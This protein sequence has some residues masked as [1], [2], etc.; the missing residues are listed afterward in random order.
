MADDEL[1]FDS[2]KC[3]IDAVTRISPGGLLTDATV[4]APPDAITECQLVPIVELPKESPCPD[5]FVTESSIF[6]GYRA[7]DSKITEPALLF[8]VTKGTCCEFDFQVTVEIPEITCPEMTSLATA[9]H[10]ITVTGGTPGALPDGKIYLTVVKDDVSCAFDFDVDFDFTFS[11]PALTSNAEKGVAAVVTQG[12][13]GSLP[14]ATISLT[15]N[16]TENCSFEFDFDFDVTFSCPALTSN[17]AEG[18]AAIVTKG[19]AGDLPE[20]TISLTV[21]NTENCSFEF[22]VDLDLTF[23][24]PA[25]TSNAEKGVA[26]VVTKGTAGDLPEATIAL[27]I[28][29]TENCSFDFDVDFDFTFSCP[30]LTSN[31]E[32][33]TDIAFLQG[34]DGSPP[35]GKIYLAVTNTENCAFEFDVNVEFTFS[36]PD[37]T[38]NAELGKD[39]SVYQG[40]NGAPPEGKIYLTVNNTIDCAFEFDVDFDFTFSCPALTSNSAEG[41]VAV[42]TQGKAGDLPEATISLTINN[43]ED[44]SFE[45]DVELDVTFS[46]PALESKAEEG[47]SIV[48]TQGDVGAL[49]EGSIYL[50]ISNTENCSFEFNVDFDLTFSCPALTSLSESGT[51]VTVTQGTPGALP[52][53]TLYL[54]VE[55]TENCSFEFTIEGDLTFSCPAIKSLATDGVPIVISRDGTEPSGKITLTVNTAEDCS[56]D[57]DVNVDLA[58]PCPIMTAVT[59]AGAAIEIS[60]GIAGKLPTGTIY[61]TA[62]PSDNCSYDFDVALDFTFSCPAITSLSDAGTSVTLT[63]NGSPAVGDTAPTGTIYLKVENTED[64]TFEFSTELELDLPCAEMTSLN[65][66]GIDVYV[67]RGID[68]ELTTGTIYLTVENTED[69]SYEFKADLDIVACCPALTSLSEDGTDVEFTAAEATATP[70]GKIYLTV[71]N[72]ENCIFEFEVGLELS[73]PE[74]SSV[75]YM[76]R[77]SSTTLTING[78]Y[79]GYI[80]AYDP[81]SNTYVD[82][83]YIEIQPTFGG[84]ELSVQTYVGV[85]VGFVGG[86]GP[87]GG[88]TPIYGASP[89]GGGGSSGGGGVLVQVL[90]TTPN[91]FGHYRANL[92]TFNPATN[93]FTVASPTEVTVYDVDSAPLLKKIY[94]G[95]FGGKES[96]GK[97][98][99][100][101]RTRD[102]VACV[103]VSYYEIDENNNYAGYLLN[104]NNDTD[105]FE[106]TYDI[107]IKDSNNL[108][109]EDQKI[110]FGR[111]SGSVGSG[112]LSLYGSGQPIND[113]LYT[114]ESKSFTQAVRVTTLSPFLEGGSY[115]LYDGYVQRFIGGV[116]GFVDWRPIKILNVI[117]NTVIPGRYLGYYSGTLYNSSVPIYLIQYTRT[118]TTPPPA[119]LTFDFVSGI[120]CFNGIFTPEFLTVCIPYGYL[121]VTT[122]TTSTAG[123]ATTSTTSTGAV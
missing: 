57:F 105:S 17:S 93:G 50:N 33:G 10:A 110:Y 60:Q 43:T 6:I 83:N 15:I 39:I 111:F 51:P 68:G 21:N 115:G 11:C 94:I 56:F 18:V 59:S 86:G 97:S 14:E 104:Y 113:Y 19:T 65:D 29:N 54:T 108:P 103:K 90:S 49:P 106:E 38:S 13:A 122:T 107:K 1:I 116:G 48:V 8:T 61:L 30:A 119:I 4:P 23:S 35:E 91:A 100:L 26:A 71:N 120:S 121:C 22:D 40:I 114:V 87:G 31:A 7:D 82:L 3:D 20:A 88:G 81:A 76:I 75:V 80:I 55:N 99:Y 73:L 102:D 123:P 84:T 62:E 32:T 79:P 47:T 53:A 58:L 117:T 112:S 44:C 63:R 9:G 66:D 45:F 85:L 37:L 96:S 67:E 5:L 12:T 78:N 72:T 95:S 2:T 27:T 69:C 16:N 24:C 70:T 25:L 41:T 109:L 36:C 74:P 98:V 34:P 64:C 28:N 77:V 118:T 92:L 42:I 101:V 52:E 46:C 89:G